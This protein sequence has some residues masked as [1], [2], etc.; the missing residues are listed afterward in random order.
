MLT[1]TSTI[2]LL[3]STYNWPAA[4]A[5][6][7]NSIRTQ[8]ILP[9]E[10]I[11]A[12][13][14]SKDETRE[15]ILNM[16]KNFPVPIIHVWQEDNGFRLAKIRNKGIARSSSDYIIQIDGDLILDKHFIEDH[17]S[18]AEE[19][20][21]IT[22][23]RALLSSNTTSKLFR[24]PNIPI[25]YTSTPFSHFFNAVRFAPLT[26]Y[27]STR[28][29][30]GGKYKYYVKGCNMSFWKKDLITVNGYDEN[31]IGWGMEDNDIAVRLLNAGVRKKFIK[32]GGVAFHLYHRENSRGKHQANSILVKAAVS[33][34]KIKAEKGILEYLVH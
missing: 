34:K 26:R 33:S 16:K 15:L 12:D 10:V 27:L 14:G 25:S 22:G 13:D 29:K 17:M 1:A 9:D 7:L 24:D 11:I 8:T 5:L 6:C 23:S 21:F 3:I 30:V 18:I 20:Y 2:S 4:L 19:G 31:F 28:Y 32:M